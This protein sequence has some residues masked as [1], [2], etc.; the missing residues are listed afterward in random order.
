LERIAAIVGRRTIPSGEVHIG[1]DAAVLAP[2]VGEALISTDVAVFGV[3]HDEYQF[4]L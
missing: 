2:I 4:T 3:P 1:D